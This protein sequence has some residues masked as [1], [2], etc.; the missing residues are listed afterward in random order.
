[1]K[2]QQA[3]PP[4]THSHTKEGL[5][6]FHISKT[7]VPVPVRLLSPLCHSQGTLPWPALPGQGLEISGLTGRDSSGPGRG[8]SMVGVDP[9]TPASQKNFTVRGTVGPQVPLLLASP[10][11]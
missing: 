2:T 10:H 6:T 11:H 9:S 7:L 3:M 4:G 1:M 5:Y 8:G